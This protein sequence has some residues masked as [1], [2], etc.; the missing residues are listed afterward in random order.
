MDDVLDG[1]EELDDLVDSEEER[2][3][4]REVIRMARRPTARGHSGVS[5][6]P[7]GRGTSA[8]RSS[9]VPSSASR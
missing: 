2:E 7:S 3:Q 5:A 6:T 8:R 9:G 1:L 4:V